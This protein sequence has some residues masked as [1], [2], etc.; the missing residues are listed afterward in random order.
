MS[1]LKTLGLALAAAFALF[2]TVAS[3]AS[4]QTLSKITT[5]NG[6][7]ATLTATETG[8]G[9]NRLTL[10][11][12]KGAFLECPGSFYTGHAVGTTNG[13]SNGATTATITPH[14]KQTSGFGEPNCKGPFGIRSTIHMNGCDYV[15]H[16]GETIPGGTEHTY[17]VTYDIICPMG[18]E[19]TVTLWTN[20]TQHTTQ[21]NTAFCTLHIPSQTNLTGGHATDTSTTDGH[22]ELTG[23]VEGLIVNKTESAIHE[24]IL[25]ANEHITNASTDMDL[26][27]EHK[28]AS[29]PTVSLSH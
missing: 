15:F 11:V 14:Y 25:C 3:A 23:T 8:A 12:P 13:V 2:A 29:E 17:A 27:V 18:N 21:P 6:L 16:I 1:N 19:I 9:V 24:G 10:P 26:T 4:A 22:F 7:P 20:E 28:N 5:S